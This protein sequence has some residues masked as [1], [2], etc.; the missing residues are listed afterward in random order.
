MH[1]LLVICYKRYWSLIWLQKSYLVTFFIEFR[2]RIRQDLITGSFTTTSRTHQHYTMSNLHRL[3]EL[4]SFLDNTLLRLQVL[5]FDALL[6]C[7]A[8][9]S[10]VVLGNF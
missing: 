5:C 2:K 3:K 1:L 9:H 7:R 4:D 6:D 8:E 10:V